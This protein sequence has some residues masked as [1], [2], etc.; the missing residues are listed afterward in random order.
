MVDK[1]VILKSIDNAIFKNLTIKCSGLNSN[2]LKEVNKFRD[3]YGSESFEVCVLID[4]KGNRISKET[5]VKEHVQVPMDEAIEEDAKGNTDL[6]L[7]HNHPS[8][9]HEIPTCLSTADM[10]ILLDKSPQTG[11]YLFKSITAEA[12]NGS[13]M[14]LIRKK[15]FEGKTNQIN[16]F[17]DTISD[18]VDE[19]RNLLDK[20]GFES[21]QK[22]IKKYRNDYYS[23]HPKMP[24]FEQSRDAWKEYR[25][26][27]IN[28]FIKN[29]QIKEKFNK[30][31]FQLII[32]KSKIKK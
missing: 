4:K 27:L 20:T 31:G 15:D 14:T 12:P 1:L 25:K 23:S 19:Y 24:S 9:K 22:W 3:E 26:G 7:D 6:H 28:D 30:Y 13:R 2:V 17:K 18:L 32:N 29:N 8:G 11:N 5:G 21:S 10:K 16:G